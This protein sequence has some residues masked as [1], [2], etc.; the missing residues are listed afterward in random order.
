M[1][2]GTACVPPRTDQVS[3]T[4][5]E[6]THEAYYLVSGE[7]KLTWDGDGPGSATVHSGECFYFPPARTYAIESVGDV[8]AVFVWTLAPSPQRSD[9]W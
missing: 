3:W 9:A 1:A 4:A 5:D 8:D 6:H 2:F 7:L